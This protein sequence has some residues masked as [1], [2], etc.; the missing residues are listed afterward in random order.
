[1]S[2][3]GAGGHDH[4]AFDALPPEAMLWINQ[5]C[6]Q[7]EKH[8]QTA[9]QIPTSDELAKFIESI[10]W[11]YPQAKAMVLEELVALDALYRSKREQFDTFEH[12]EKTTGELADGTQLGDYQ[13]LALIGRGGMGRV[14][15]AEHRLMGRSVAIK[16][17]DRRWVG[18]P[19]M[20]VRFEREIR[21][22][23][24]LAH[25]HVV[26]AL[27]AR[28][29]G[30]E[31]YLVTEWLDGI[32]L[33]KL[34]KQQGPLDPRQAINYCID[35]AKGLSYAHRLGIVHRDVKPSNLFRSASGQVKVLDLGLSRI[36]MEDEIAKNGVTQS[37]Y[38]LG[39]AAFMAP[40]QARSPLLAEERSDIYS[41]GCTLFY[42]LVG[43]PPY[44]GLSSVDVLL[45]HA[46]EEL[47]PVRT[48]APAVPETLDNY[49][50]RMLAKQPI[51]RPQSMEQVIEHL[52]ALLATPDLAGDEPRSLSPPTPENSSILRRWS[53]IV[54]ASLLFVVMGWG[55]W[56]WIEGV[57][58]QQGAS[59]NASGL[60]FDGTN[61]FASVRNF[62]AVASP[63]SGIDVVVTPGNG[64]LPANVVTWA[65][66]SILVVFIT[67]QGFWGV[68]CYT[69]TTSHLEISNTPAESGRKYLV[70]ALMD[71]DGARLFVDGQQVTT[72]RQSY[73]M[74]ATEP[75]LYVAGMPLG[76]FPLDR[77]T[78]FFSGTIHQVRIYRDGAV[79][80]DQ[81]DARLVTD[82]TI[83]LFTFDAPHGEVVS[84]QSSN[85]W[86]AEFISATSA[87]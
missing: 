85:G 69:A 53:G 33:A 21:A 59:V 7:W 3:T 15:K 62:D 24:K 61:R 38:L 25:P 40:E 65:G 48:L 83:A 36:V 35:A 86:Q 87:R 74:R 37:A 43:K 51:D 12:G 50:R 78:R 6:D 16:T 29:E 47:P 17:L 58:S 22:L 30:D 64:A 10:E 79:A 18:D 46:T 9:S 1:M 76:F 27:D 49:L 70:S 4:T 20:R 55:A 57:D 28:Y 66:P 54:L 56:Q 2:S 81:D 84:D 32:D 71:N 26:T 44:S 60:L 13:I 82:Q 8:W 72:R 42:L 68:A 14:Y 11:R 39:T 77:G 45:A 52:S 41:L 75:A 23:A 19:T 67:Q 34:V 31:I 80:T 63:N 5:V 73:P